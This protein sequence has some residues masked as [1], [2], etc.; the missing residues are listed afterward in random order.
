MNT[1]VIDQLSFER[2]D[3]SLFENISAE[4]R[5]GDIVQLSGANGTGKTTLMRLL[6]GLLA[7]STG[8]IS[9]NQRSTNSFEFRSSLLYLGHHVGVKATMTPYENLSWYFS[10]NGAKRVPQTGLA[11]DP[12]IAPTELEAALDGVGLKAYRDIPCYQLSAGQ[13]RGAALARLSVSE[14]PLWLL[15]E[16]FTAIDA[17]GVAR[18]EQVIEQR[19][20]QGGI[21]ILTTH[22]AWRSD[23]VQIL[24]LEEF[25]P[26]RQSC[27]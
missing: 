18:L 20:E 25:S 24:N 21:I 2:D 15:D 11:A 5:S 26:G 17:A 14:A 4:W 9:W 13:Q 8:E 23:R 3:L 19:A 22:Q 16:P 7:P 10:L 1:L 12:V 6:A 27:T